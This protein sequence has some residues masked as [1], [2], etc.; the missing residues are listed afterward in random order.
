[1]RDRTQALVQSKRAEHRVQRLEA[2]AAPSRRRRERRLWLSSA[3]AR[4]IRRVAKWHAKY[5]NT[6]GGP[7]TQIGST[8]DAPSAPSARPTRIMMAKKPMPS[9]MAPATASNLASARSVAEERRSMTARSAKLAPREAQPNL[10]ICGANSALVSPA[11]KSNHVRV[12]FAV[13]Q[14]RN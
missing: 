10:R 11:L 1:M 5:P 6:I 4:C 8:G 7:P 12:D 14:S 13:H 2:D 9:R 3:R